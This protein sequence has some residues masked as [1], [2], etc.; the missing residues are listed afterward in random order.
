MRLFKIKKINLYYTRR[1]TLKVVTNGEAHFSG[2]AP[3][4]HSFELRRKHCSGGDPLATC[5]EYDL[6][7]LE[8]ETETVT[9]PIGRSDT[10]FGIKN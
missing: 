3:G 4:Q 10:S 6:I 2:L 7:D 8:M 5:T 9:T 1:I